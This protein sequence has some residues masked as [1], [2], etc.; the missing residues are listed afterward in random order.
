MAPS[1]SPKHWRIVLAD[2]INETPFADLSP[3]LVLDAME[4][5]GL[6]TDGRLLVLN[7]FE[8]RVYQVGIEGHLPV[9]AKFYRPDR[10]T[11]AAIEEEHAF[12]NELVEDDLP[13]AAPIAVNGETLCR[14]ANHRF[15]LSPW[16]RGRPP[17]CC[18]LGH[19]ERLGRTL[20]RI[21]NV[22]ARKPFR[23]RQILSA[24]LGRDALVETLS[25]PLIADHV[26]S[27]Y[28]AAAEQLLAH[29]DDA[30]RE[31]PMIRVHGDAH[32][33][34]L[35]WNDNGPNFVDFDDALM[36]PVAQDLWILMSAGATEADA[37]LEGYRSLRT[38]EPTAL[39]AV[40][41][42][43]SLRLIRYGGWLSQRYGDPAFPRAFPFATEA[44]FWQ[45]H[46]DALTEQ[47][48]IM[49]SQSF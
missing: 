32:L 24:N 1:H 19:L 36:G 23:H 17:E 37:L 44:S 46:C 16:I 30:L 35:L 8:N 39:Q 25:G 40:E 4:A 38:L 5:I 7:S 18:D 13:V 48:G 15:S 20:A 11:D 9:L 10:W 41:A 43:R 28:A 27:R 3:E 33:G 12:L 2:K 49:Q 14:F 21:H 22:G 6:A 47:V 45:E 29:I 31:C 26:R 34:N 42:L